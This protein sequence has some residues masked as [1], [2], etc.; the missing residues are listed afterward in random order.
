MA[1]TLRSL[2]LLLL[3]AVVWELSAQ[4]DTERHINPQVRNKARGDEL[5]QR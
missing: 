5:S 3:L 1:P 2:V 4:G